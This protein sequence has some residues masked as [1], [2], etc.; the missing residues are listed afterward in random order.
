MHL[1][2]GGENGLRFLKP[3]TTA[4]LGCCHSI[5][6]RVRDHETLADCIVQ[7][8]TLQLVMLFLRMKD[9]LI[10]CDHDPVSTI[11]TFQAEEVVSQH[12]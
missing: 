10:F 9:Q 12:M 11:V 4:H 6:I 1:Q 3:C 2:E 5:C 8:W 7:C